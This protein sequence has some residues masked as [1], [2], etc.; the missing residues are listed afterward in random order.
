MD[1]PLSYTFLFGS[2]KFTSAAVLNTVLRAALPA[3]E[4]VS[5]VAPL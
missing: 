3:E 1:W 2:V 4:V 5:V